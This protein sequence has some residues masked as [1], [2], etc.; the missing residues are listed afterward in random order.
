MRRCSALA[1]ATRE[2]ST[3]LCVF[4]PSETRLSQI[5]A[6]DRIL[7]QLRTMRGLIH[8]HLE[9]LAELRQKAEILCKETQALIDEYHWLKARFAELRQKYG[10]TP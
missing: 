3:R 5:N 4:A 2:P 8:I 1:I 6:R 10:T 9:D 7:G